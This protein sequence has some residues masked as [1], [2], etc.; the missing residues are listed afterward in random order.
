MVGC[1]VRLLLDFANIMK[2][3]NKIF[4]IAAINLLQ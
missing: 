3:L 2:M 1:S 4:Q